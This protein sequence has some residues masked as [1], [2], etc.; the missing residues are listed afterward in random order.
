MRKINHLSVRGFEM[1]R[2][3][4]KREDFARVGANSD[5]DN[6]DFSHIV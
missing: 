4:E 6:Y 5:T 2:R 1:I 3:F